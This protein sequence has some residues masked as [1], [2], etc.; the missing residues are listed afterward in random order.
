[1]PARPSE[2][3]TSYKNPKIQYVRDLLASRK[4][5]D[6]YGACVI[7]GVRL[8]EEAIQAG[9]IPLM[10]ISTDG[11]SERGEKLLNSVTDKKTVF[12]KVPDDLMAKL[13]VTET[14]QGILLVIP[15]ESRPI[16]KQPDFILI[17]DQIKDPGNMGTMLRTAN[18]AGAQAVIV[19]PGCVDPY[20]PKVLRAGMGAHFHLPLVFQTW[21]E[22]SDFTKNYNTPLQL[23]LAESSTGIPMW[24]LDLRR[25]TAIIIGGEADGASTGAHQ[26]ATNMVTIP[27][28]GGSESLNAAISAGILLFE[29][30]RQRSK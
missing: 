23:L 10:V 2:Y 9:V 18:A 17:L 14:D 27:M 30:V 25:P 11:L 15:L 3:I 6:E 19:T 29:V 5:R 13:S 4:S 16:P 28:P 8:S 22:I 24:E 1:M 21:E 12:L 20:S 26:A 7:V